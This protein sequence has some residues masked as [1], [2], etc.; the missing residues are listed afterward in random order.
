[1]FLHRILLVF[2]F[3]LL[4]SLFQFLCFI[5]NFSTFRIV[6]NLWFWVWADLHLLVCML[7][8]IKSSW[9]IRFSFALDGVDLEFTV[10]LQGTFSQGTCS[11]VWLLVPVNSFHI[12]QQLLFL[13]RISG[14]NE[15][16]KSLRVSIRG[17]NELQWGVKRASQNFCPRGLFQDQPSPGNSTSGVFKPLEISNTG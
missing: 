17:G 4:Y 12:G 2:F 6:F 5:L 10:C 15:Q 14:Q 1:M 11:R 13:V 9:S 7:M 16:P 8:F 3:Y